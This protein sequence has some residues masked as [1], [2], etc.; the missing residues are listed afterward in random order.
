V[1]YKC[2]FVLLHK[3]R[4]AMAE[5]MKGR[6]LGGEGKTVEADGR[7]CDGEQAVSG[8]QRLLA[9]ACERGVRTPFRLRSMYRCNLCS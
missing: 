5:E 3:L 8:F 4:E 2:A 7:F 6:T 1:S 9:T